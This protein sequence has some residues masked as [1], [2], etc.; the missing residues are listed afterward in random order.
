[1][2]ISVS[3]IN[4]YPFK[5]ACAVELSSSRLTNKGLQ[6]DRRLMFVDENGIVISARE[7]Q[8]LLKLKVLVEDQDIHFSHGED[9]FQTR[10]PHDLSNKQTVKIFSSTTHATLVSNEA[11]LWLSGILK[12]KGQLVYMS[13]EDTRNVLQK[14]GGQSGDVVSFADENPLLLISEESLADL[15]QPT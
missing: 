3:S 10:L 11:S 14:A 6:D 13:D 5:S 1:M 4:I 7:C 9:V 2:K 12:T 15:K 8:A